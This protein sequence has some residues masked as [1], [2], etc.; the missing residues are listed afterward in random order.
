[1]PLTKV[2][3]QLLTGAITTNASSGIDLPTAS[4]RVT[5]DFT[6]ATVASRV[7][8]QTNTTNGSTGIYAIPNG[9]STAASWQATNNANPTNASKILIATN[10][11]TDVQL[12][13]GINGSGTY[14]PMTFYNNGSEKFRLDTAGNILLGGTAAR[15]TTVGAAHLDLFNGTAPAG[16]LT[17]GVSLYSASGDLNFMDAA[18]S[19][20]KVGYRNV[21]SAGAAK[22][23]NY[24]ITTSDVGEFVEL[25]TSGAITVPNST[26]A[27]GDVVSVFNNTATTAT[28]TLS[29]TN[30]YIA[31]VNTNKTSVTLAARGITTILFITSTLCVLTGNVS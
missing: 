1:M 4:A 30:A 22:N 13:S 3:A 16:T 17:N 7:I 10:G 6:N 19:A 20:F 21:P 28:I 23:S 8:F 25:T 26:F 31:G 29:T 18:G 12:V 14:L 2:D 11:S 5:A 9:S 24:S 27:A 15:A